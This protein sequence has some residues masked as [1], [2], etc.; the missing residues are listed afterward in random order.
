MTKVIFSEIAKQELDDAS[1]YYEAQQ[2]GLGIVFREEA[3]SSVDRIAKYPHAWSVERGDVRKYLLHKFP[4]KILYSVEEDH[5][6]ILAVAHQHRK[7]DYR[8][9]S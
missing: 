3:K 1:S 5:I 2:P 4:Y 9:E 6:V 8:I 7:P